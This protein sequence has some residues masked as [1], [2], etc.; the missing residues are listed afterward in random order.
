MISNTFRII[1]SCSSICKRIW[2]C[3]KLTTKRLY[4]V[5]CGVKCL[6]CCVVFRD[7]VGF[8]VLLCGVAWCCVVLR[9]AVGFWVLLCGV[10]WCCVVLCDSVGFLVLLCRVAWCCVVLCYVVWC[11]VVLRDAVGFWMLLCGVAWCCVVLCDAVGF[12]VLLCGVVW[13]L[14]VLCYVVWCCVILWVFGCYYVVLCDVVWCCV[15]RLFYALVWRGVVALCGVVYVVC[16]CLVLHP[17]SAL[18]RSQTDFS[19]SLLL[20]GLEALFSVKDFPWS[21][22][23]KSLRKSGPF[24][25]VITLT[26]EREKRK[27]R[28]IGHLCLHLFFSQGNKIHFKK[29]TARFVGVTQVRLK[30]V[31]KSLPAMTTIFD[32]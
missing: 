12:W 2:D 3:V 10:V 27:I 4:R 1:H 24:C 7:T 30:M 28:K 13:C 25:C 20:V 31:Y 6:L 11:F 29:F 5:L 22:S 8:W 15:V 23:Q 9:D 21:A 17:L 26:R 18:N 32:F 16:C 14:V 19:F